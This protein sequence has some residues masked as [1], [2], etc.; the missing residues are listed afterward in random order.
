MKRLLLLFLLIFPAFASP[1]KMPIIGVQ[2][3]GEIFIGLFAEL[4]LELV[5]G[6]G[7]VFFN[8]MPLA[9]TDTQASA[10]LAVDVACQ[11]LEMDCSNKDFLYSINANS[12]MIGGPS[13]GSAMAILAMSELSG[14]KLKNDLA[15]TGTINPDKSIG[16]V[17]GI[18]EKARVCQDYGLKKILIPI[19]T[20]YLFENESFT[21][22]II[23]VETI[24]DAFS[25]FTG[26]AF[27]EPSNILEKSGFNSFMKIM[28]EELIENADQ[29]FYE[30][31]E[32]LNDSYLNNSDFNSINEL[33][34]STERQKSEMEGLYNSSNYY[35]ASSY[36]VQ[37]AINSLYT[38]YLI[39]YFLNSSDYEKLSNEFNETINSFE[40]N[41]EERLIIDNINDFEAISISIERFFEAKAL[42]NDSFEAFLRNDSFSALY[43][44]AFANVRLKTSESWFG[45]KD[46]LKGDLNYFFNQEDFRDLAYTRIENAKTLLNYAKSIQESYYTVSAQ[47]FIDTSLKA[48]HE[49]NIA[50][51][52]FESLKSIS[53]SNLA[54]SLSGVN[55][56]NLNERINVLMNLA[57][58][59]I[60]L[61]E[62]KNVTPILAYSYYEYG[63][64]FKDSEP[65]QAILF[66]EYSKQFSILSEELAHQAIPK[67]EKFIAETD[68][69]IIPKISISLLL[70]MLFSLII[71]EIYYEAALYN[72]R[73]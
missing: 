19:G 35:S 20:K 58:K 33:A 38:N 73:K 40:K 71:L 32:K 54:L 45:L 70:G 18:V 51:S 28:S 63:E 23:E 49:G 4:S 64:N 55:E 16:V 53:N 44:L 39:D 67:N 2:E 7:R 61:A 3:S 65:F 13:A 30:M 24:N 43:N 52:L 11:A 10:R 15:I 41:F 60:N 68:S 62:S 48:Y 14:I 57:S 69:M 66:F 22:E 42:F 59:N 56:K 50:Y 21:M 12:P 27:I 5:N 8:T 46:L 9:E 47:E 36:S 37:V 34:N 6:S 25:H 72:K 31:I 29:L 17:G 26:I 1:A